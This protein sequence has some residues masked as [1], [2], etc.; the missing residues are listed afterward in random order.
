MLVYTGKLRFPVAVIEPKLQGG[1]NHW[2]HMKTAQ[3]TTYQNLEPSTENGHN[4]LQYCPSF[5][6]PWT[7]WTIQ[8]TIVTFHS[9]ENRQFP[10]AAVKRTAHA[11]CAHCV[12]HF[13]LRRW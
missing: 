11:H 3:S 6:F 9:C 2:P 12:L 4:L 13:Q 5:W 1:G 10:F 8:N 7:I